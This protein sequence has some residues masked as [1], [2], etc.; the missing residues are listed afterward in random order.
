MTPTTSKNNP[1]IHSNMSQVSQDD[2]AQPLQTLRAQ[3]YGMCLGWPS[4]PT[5]EKSANCFQGTRHLPQSHVLPQFR[6]A[7]AQEVASF[8]TSHA[9]TLSVSNP[10]VNDVSPLSR[11]QECLQFQLSLGWHWGKLKKV[12]KLLVLTSRHKQNGIKYTY[13]TFKIQQKPR[14]IL[15][16]EN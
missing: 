10:K 11:S 6:P 4:K 5:T 3:R 12:G 13:K 15:P 14:V 7:F 16:H 8:K 2:W 9:P 1:M